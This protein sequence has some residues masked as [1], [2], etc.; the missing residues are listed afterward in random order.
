MLPK[1][2]HCA[3]CNHRFTTF[4]WAHKCKACGG[5]V[6]SSCLVGKGGICKNCND[7]KEARKIEDTIERVIDFYIANGSLVAVTK[8]NAYL[9]N[10]HEEHKGGDMFISSLELKKHTVATDT[11]WAHHQ[12]K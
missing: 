5:E 7:A 12:R 4:T 11:V 6:C 1:T 9:V 8:K 3:I 2:T 10:V